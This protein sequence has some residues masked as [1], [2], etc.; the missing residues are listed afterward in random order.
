MDLRASDIR[1][2]TSEVKKWLF[3]DQLEHPEDFVLYRPRS[4]GGLGL[5]HPKYKALA[6]L[7]RSFMETALHPS[8]CKKSIPPCSLFVECGGY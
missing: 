2:I 8:F 5:H 1:Q 7:I 6:E 4:A 3:A